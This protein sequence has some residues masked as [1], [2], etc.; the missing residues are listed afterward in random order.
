VIKQM[1]MWGARGAELCG[2]VR[3]LELLEPE[4]PDLLRVLT[5]HRVGD[6]GSEPDAYPGLFSATPRGF[7]D[8]AAHLARSHRVISLE[9]L[10]EARRTRR[11]L[12]PRALLL[13][14]DDAYRDFA[15]H[16]WPALRRHGLPVTLFVPTAFPDDLERIPWWD[17][18]YHAVTATPRRAPLECEVG[19]LALATASERA[20]SFKRLRDRVKTLDHDSAMA[21]VDRLC[22][23]LGAPPQAHRMLGW[24][25]LRTLARDGVSLAA[26]TRTH[27][28][29][30]RIPAARVREEAVGSLRDLA[31]EVGAV[32]PVFAYPSGAFDDAVVALLESEGFELAFTTVRGVNDLRRDHPLRLRRINVGMRTSRAAQRVQ[33]LS[34]IGGLQRRWL[35]TSPRPPAPARAMRA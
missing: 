13:T 29:M 23:G 19:P 30:T 20:A 33:L 35:R 25:E 16:A 34:S 11:P 5:Y 12:P 6:P 27:P 3:L 26:H 8:Q 4:R 7:A 21:W 15:E 18:L 9:E 10:L 2:L 17:R 22:A 32:A 31:R 24:D 28:L 14:F 1:A